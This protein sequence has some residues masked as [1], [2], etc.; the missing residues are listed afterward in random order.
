MSE[1]R[2]VIERIQALLGSRQVWAVLFTVL[3]V[4]TAGCSGFM[5]GD[6]GGASDQ[7]A[8][9]SVPEGVDTVM[10]FDSGIVDD[11]TTESLVNGLMEMG[12]ESVD[13]VEGDSYEDILAEAESES[14]LSRDGFNSLTVFTNAEEIDQEEYVGMIAETDWTWEELQSASEE[15]FEDIEEDS[16]NGVTVYKETDAMDEEA[17]IA[18]FGDGTFAFGTPQAVR[19]VVDTREGEA[20]P[21]SGRLRDAYDRAADGY[22]KLAMLV[23]EE[24]VDEAGQQAGV[25]ASFAPTPDVVTMTYHT[26]GDTMN[27]DAQLTMASQEEAQQ[28]NQLASAT[29][30]PPTG[31][32]S[33]GQG[34]P[35]AALI[36][37]TS[38]SQDG[39]T[40]TMNFSITPDELLALFE[41]L[42]TMGSS[43]PFSVGTGSASGVA[44]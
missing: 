18:D 3:M 2:N 39:D 32:Q 38:V 13:G 6:D 12:G 22:M 23:P 24:Q 7:A 44:G 29:L 31:D 27:L 15:E 36:E 30:E 5:G 40:V 25:G 26:D 33:G 35:F 28:L 21:F 42:G 20:S 17:W 34:G 37:A 4:S 16:Y 8:I 43:Q 19:D 1:T 14:D 11:Q 9:D 41:N 10:Y